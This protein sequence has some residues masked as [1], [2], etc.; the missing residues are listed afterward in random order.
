MHWQTQISIHYSTI[1]DSTEKS[2]YLFDNVGAELL[3]G[4]CGNVVDKAS[5]Q[6]LGE[7]GLAEID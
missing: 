4:E 6:W 5:G 7:G 3:L 2:T 1:N